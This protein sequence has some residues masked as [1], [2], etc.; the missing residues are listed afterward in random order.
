[1]SSPGQRSSKRKR[2]AALDDDVHGDPANDLLQPS[3]R[4]ASGEDAADSATQD[5]TSEIKQK[6]QELN[7]AP[8]KRARTRSNATEHTLDSLDGRTKR[9]STA[10]SKE[11]L[12]IN[13]S[14]DT[15]AIAPP[16]KGQLQDP[17]GY[18]TNP[19]PIGR[20][21]RIYADGVFDLFHLG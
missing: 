12:S 14:E 11:G 10:S 19:P 1:M 20:P 4:D 7:G 5:I 3:S 15:P 21:V 17:V 6:K 9:K 16:P 18:K 2:S 8:N 13:L